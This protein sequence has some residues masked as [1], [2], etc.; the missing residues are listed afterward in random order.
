MNVPKHAHRFQHWKLLAILVGATLAVAALL[1]VEL[2]DARLFDWQR[3]AARG[4]VPVVTA[5]PSY[6][7]P[8]LDRL[9]E[10][11]VSSNRGHFGVVVRNLSTGQYADY[12]PD[13]LFYAASLY[14]LG[15]LYTVLA[16]VRAGR[17]A[18]DEQLTVTA[19]TRRHEGEPSLAVGE[20][21]AVGD[22][23][24]RM[25]AWSD[26]TSAYLL[27]D[28]VGWEHVN[29]TMR[30][31]G[32]TG[33]HV[34]A[35]AATTRPSE[36]AE[37]LTAIATDQAVDRKASAHMR[38]VLLG[39]TRN[40]RLPAYL[41][42]GV[43]V[44]HKTGELHGLRHDAGIVYGPRG[45]YVVVIMVDGIEDEEAG[46]EVIARLSSAVYDYF[47]SG[48]VVLPPWTDAVAVTRSISQTHEDLH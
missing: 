35:P 15:V 18:L 21:L 44:A 10:E 33:T 6:T 23:L 3:I 31:L 2:L 41:P 5:A 46:Q 36:V 17:V 19:R 9:V 47:T 34:G 22:A 27:L 28:R 38:T 20:R 40:D 14:K 25:V 45:V 26:N 12:N 48:A 16:D 30:R 4:P 8:T 29:E 24:Q 7:D 1:G 37:L 43:R 11:H 13:D 32:L 42:P 39:Q